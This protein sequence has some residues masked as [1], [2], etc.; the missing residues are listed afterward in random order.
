[1]KK[2]IQKKGNVCLN[3]IFISGAL[4]LLDGCGVKGVNRIAP[5][6]VSH[7]KT[8]YAPSIE[9][10]GKLLPQEKKF[11][12]TGMIAS[13]LDKTGK[14]SITTSK[15]VTQGAADLAADSLA[16]FRFFKVKTAIPHNFRDNPQI[17][18]FNKAGTD[19]FVHG[20]IVTLESTQDQRN[21]SF[22]LD[23]VNLSHKVTRVL[24]IVHMTVNSSLDS[25][26]FINESGRLA[27]GNFK[28]EWDIFENEFGFFRILGDKAVT[29]DAAIKMSQVADQA[30][31]EAIERGM[32]ELVGDMFDVPYRR[33]LP[34]GDADFSEVYN[35]IRGDE[36]PAR[37]MKGVA[38]PTP[39]NAASVD[40]APTPQA[41]SKPA[42]RKR[43]SR[44][45]RR[46]AQ[47]QEA[48]AK[49][50]Q[51]AVIKQQQIAQQQA[52]MA[53]RQQM[54]QQQA[55]QQAEMAR[56]Q[57]LAQQQEATQQAATQRAPAQ[58]QAA[59]A[60]VKSAPL[61]SMTDE[62]NKLEAVQKAQSTKKISAES[63]PL[64]SLEEDQANL[65]PVTTD[66]QKLAP[67]AAGAAAAGT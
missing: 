3:L 17:F 53:R 52:E 45:E 22:S 25:T 40:E 46:A 19:F 36:S 55:Q 12:Y 29:L 24:A 47:Q 1:M 61:T 30:L 64:T 48:K 21:F 35:I 32:V 2:I 44:A 6:Y 5:T 56:R 50:Q 58:Q 43:M 31:H 54:A 51:Q 66:S 37:H 42:S 20:S 27:S 28:A 16:K 9:C 15:P 60:A 14:G 63:E 7:Y 62:K 8:H 26:V 4:F 23:P 49:K 18:E 39:Q 67:L 65:A 34:K 57:Q 11:K 13:F 59:G 41:T 38:R 10:I 33:C